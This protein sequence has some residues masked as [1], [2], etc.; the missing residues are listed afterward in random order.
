MGGFE[1]VE[2][3]GIAVQIGVFYFEEDGR[4]E[5]VEVDAVESV[6]AEV[7]EEGEVAEVGGASDFE[8]DEVSS[9][10]EVAEGEAWGAADDGYSGSAR[11]VGVSGEGVGADC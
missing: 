9:V 7:E 1:T 2:G 11:G 5:V 8:V 3:F 4:V 6:G 10:A